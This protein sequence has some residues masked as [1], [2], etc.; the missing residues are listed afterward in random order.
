M[1]VRTYRIGTAARLTNVAVATLRNW[2][3]RY[4]LV[5]PARNGGRQRLYSVEQIQ[6][7]RLLKR[8]VDAGLSAGEAHGR[9]REHLAPL[10]RLRTPSA[11]DGSRLA[12]LRVD[13]G[14]ARRRAAALRDEAGAVTAHAQAAHARSD[15]LLAELARRSPPRGPKPN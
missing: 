5:V 10:A 15:D 9:L 1:L 7:L 14:V 4:R 3:R 13:A 11:V 2:E 6:Q 8:W 12:A